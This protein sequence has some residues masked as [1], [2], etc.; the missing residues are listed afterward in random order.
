MQYRAVST[1][2]VTIKNTTL[3]W[4]KHVVRD[5]EVLRDV[6]VLIVP[7]TSLTSLLF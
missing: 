1:R 3:N 5:I 6:L 4:T 7:A 2:H